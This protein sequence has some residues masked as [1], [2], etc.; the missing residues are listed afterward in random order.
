MKVPIDPER[1]N[2]R[3]IGRVVDTL[4]RGG[5]VVYPTDTVYGIAADMFQKRAVDKI[6]RIKGKAENVP[7]TFIFDEFK[8]IARYAIVTDRNY[9]LMKR[10]LPGPYTLIVEASRLVPRI[11]TRNR[12]TIGIRMPDHV[13]ARSIVESMGNPV[14][15]S[16]V[17]MPTTD[18]VAY[19]DPHEIDDRLG[20][21]VDL[22]VDSGLIYP[23]PSTVVDLTGDTPRLIR[24]GKGP[25][26]EIGE[27]ELVD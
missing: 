16:S 15:S 10:I 18:D 2:P 25:I 7:L 21:Q 23:E 17:P 14:V 9:R 27:I 20:R 12:R 22:V 5:I 4:Q 11:M 6:Y 24:Q 8:D 13:V 26:E 3:L 1:P 19:N